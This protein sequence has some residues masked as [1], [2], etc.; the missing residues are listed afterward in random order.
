MLRDCIKCG[1][2]A[3]PMIELTESIEIGLKYTLCDKCFGGAYGE[4]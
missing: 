3:N 4:K 2:L 1:C